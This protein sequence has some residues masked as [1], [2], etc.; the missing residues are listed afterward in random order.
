MQH[1]GFL[2]GTQY[3][4]QMRC[5]R[6]SARGYWSEWSPGRNYTTHE[7]GGCGVTGGGPLCLARQ[8]S[9]GGTATRIT[10]LSSLAT[11]LL[12]QPPRGSWMRG[13]ALGRPGQAGGWRCSCAGR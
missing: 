7:K 4:F 5:R 8:H 2:F 6:S 11:F 13:G 3:R 10:P 12:L 9:C 1:C